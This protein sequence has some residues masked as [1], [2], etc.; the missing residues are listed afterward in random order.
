MPAELIS[1]DQA[2]WRLEQSGIS[3]RA[4]VELLVRSPPLV[5]GIFPTNELH[6]RIDLS[7]VTNFR[8]KPDNLVVADN[9]K[10]TDI[11]LDWRELCAALKNRGHT[12]SWSWL[13]NIT[14]KVLERASQPNRARQ[15][16]GDP[17]PTALLRDPPLAAPQQ[18][19]RARAE[20]FESAVFAAP[21]PASG[22]PPPGRRGPK[23]GKRQTTAAAMRKDLENGTL[24][25]VDLRR[26]IEKQL[27]VRY[28]VS[29][30]TARKARYDVLQSPVGI[31]ISTFDK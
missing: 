9:I 12:V 5:L 8:A 1:L 15:I 10:W 13:S 16:L 14:P 28:G 21:V 7:R 27:S 20:W 29:R 24:T 11:K 31:S 3:G 22:K 30:E 18:A 4:F 17:R 25:I 26:M 2:S 23:S 19:R 6:D